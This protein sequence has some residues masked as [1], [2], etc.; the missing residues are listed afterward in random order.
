MKRLGLSAGVAGIGV[1]SLWAAGQIFESLLKNFDCS[2][3]KKI[4]AGMDTT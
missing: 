3:F 2:L 4:I 1:C